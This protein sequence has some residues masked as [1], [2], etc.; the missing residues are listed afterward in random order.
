MDHSLFIITIFRHYALNYIKYTI[1]CH[2]LFSVSFFTRNNSTYNLLS[3]SDFVIPQVSTV[4]KGPTSISYYGPIICSLVP[5]KI[6]YTDS[7]KSFKSKTR[8]RKPKNCHCCICKNYI[9]N[10]RFLE[11]FG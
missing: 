11:T 10:V 7:L 8:T 3:K 6:R 9:P 5:E 4:F 1:T 2:K